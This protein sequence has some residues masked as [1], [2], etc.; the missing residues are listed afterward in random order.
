MKLTLKVM[1]VIF[2][3]SNANFVY[4][5]LNAKCNQYGDI[6]SQLGKRFIKT[7]HMM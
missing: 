4:H 5:T 2:L 6:L 3:P 7:N 1:V